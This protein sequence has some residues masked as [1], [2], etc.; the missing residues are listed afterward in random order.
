[1][2]SS[3]VFVILSLFLASASVVSAKGDRRSNDELRKEALILAP[4]LEAIDALFAKDCAFGYQIKVFDLYEGMYE[5][6]GGQITSPLLEEVGMAE[7]DR[8]TLGWLTFLEAGANSIRKVQSESVTNAE[9]RDYT[10]SRELIAF[11]YYEGD[12]SEVNFRRFNELMQICESFYLDLIEG[13]SLDFGPLG[14]PE[15]LYERASK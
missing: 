13:E 5:T 10:H 3:V 11:E 12:P 1:M 8:L 4:A 7:A 14:Y 2:R 9:F 6:E 15:N